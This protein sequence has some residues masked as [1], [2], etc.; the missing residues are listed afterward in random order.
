[1]LLYAFFFTLVPA[2]GGLTLWVVSL[3]LFPANV[4]LQAGV[5]AG[6]IAYYLAFTGLLYGSLYSPHALDFSQ[7][8]RLAPP[9]SHY[10]LRGVGL[11]EGTDDAAYYRNLFV[12]AGMLA[13]PVAAFVAR[14]VYRDLP[15]D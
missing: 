13:A 1:M 2:V 9:L 11:L 12:L 15:L 4:P 8:D 5:R 10:A 6:A 3:M 7:L 14:Q